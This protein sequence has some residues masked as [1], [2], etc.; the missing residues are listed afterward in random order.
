MPPIGSDVVYRT[1]LF[2]EQQYRVTRFTPADENGPD[3][4]VLTDADDIEQTF[5]LPL[6]LGESITLTDTGD[7]FVRPD[8][9]SRRDRVR[10][11]AADRPSA[12]V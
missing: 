11:P 12:K 6:E 8:R 10:A 1:T 7:G 4:V 9:P 2:G 3:E 5:A